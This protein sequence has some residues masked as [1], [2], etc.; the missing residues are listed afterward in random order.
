MLRSGV[1][2][3]SELALWQRTDRCTLHGYDSNFHV[4][5]LGLQRESLHAEVA[6]HASRQIK[7]HVKLSRVCPAYVD[8]SN[9]DI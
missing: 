5:Q 9:I 2:V 3:K 8:T 1:L 7:S 4:L 6:E